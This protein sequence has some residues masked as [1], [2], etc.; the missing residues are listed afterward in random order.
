MAV[1]DTLKLLQ[2]TE[3]EFPLDKIEPYQK[4][5]IEAM[6]P[7]HLQTL[8]A[9][10]H[11]SQSLFFN[12]FVRGADEESK[13][14][15]AALGEKHYHNRC[16][17]KAMIDP[18]EDAFETLLESELALIQ[19]YATLGQIEPNQQVKRLFDTIVFDHLDHV[20][21]LKQN[22]KTGLGERLEFFLKGMFTLTEGRPY[23]QQRT[24][25]Q[26][27]I[28]G[29]LEN[30]VDA[31]TWTNVITMKAGERHANS[32]YLECLR[33]SPSKDVRT[34]CMNYG[35]VELA[36]THMLGSL[37]KANLNDWARVCMIEYCNLLTLRRI[38][39]MEP[40]AQFKS[41]FQRMI[42]LTEETFKTVTQLA[43]TLGKVDVKT[44]TASTHEKDRPKQKIDD[45]L[46]G[47][48]DLR[49]KQ[50][51]PKMT[52]TMLPE[53]KARTQKP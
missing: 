41:V 32:L 34:Q 2:R 33:H 18:T 27:V 23:N 37:F 11:A 28:Q 50:V 17:L 10:E 42:P 31:I 49:T 51:T 29:P 6:T 53:E 12:C 5:T 45:Y 35:H 46:K 21:A 38:T 43:Q 44:F 8:L 40:N 9:G 1:Q 22:F 4:R 30:T 36:H 14:H 26:G 25:T 19:N 52:I 7:L 47:I 39:E 13:Q 15:F 20:N 24:E 48:E 3:Q 16:L